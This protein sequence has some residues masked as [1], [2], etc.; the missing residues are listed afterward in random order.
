MRVPWKSVV[1][2]NIHHP[3]Q[4][5][6][7]RRAG[8][9]PHL[10]VHL[11][12]PVLSRPPQNVEVSSR[13]IPGRSRVTTSKA[14]S[15]GGVM[16][17]HSRDTRSRVTTS[18]RRDALRGRRRLHVNSF[19]GHPFACAHFSTSRCPPPAAKA[20][21]NSFQGHPF[22]CAH[23]STSR[24]PPLAAPLHVNSFQGHPFACAHF[25]VSRVPC[26]AAVRLV[27]QSQGHPFARNHFNTSTCPPRAAPSHVV[28]FPGTS[29][30]AKPL[31]RLLPAFARGFRARPRVLP[32]I[33]HR[34]FTRGRVA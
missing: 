11:R 30:C 20:H 15:A 27:L 28:S 3:V 34:I 6:L 7:F 17:S 33:G 23:F 18:A 4:L 16:S 25:S 10:R 14:P 29:V 26:A 19:Q 8:S 31:D 32:R 24:C 21:V 13:L 2:Q 1:V 12:K 5:F 9:T 22:A